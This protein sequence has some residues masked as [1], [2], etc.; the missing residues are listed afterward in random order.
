MALS[1]I[2]MRLHH[3]RVFVCWGS[4]AKAKRGSLSGKD[5]GPNASSSRPI[6]H[7]GWEERPLLEKETLSVGVRRD[8]GS[9]P[10]GNQQTQPF[11]AFKVAP[12]SLSGS[13]DFVTTDLGQ[14]FK[15]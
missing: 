11:S 15:Q 12:R 7:G 10:R 14:S 1:A 6:R 8:P 13:R 3:L 5:C 4:A 9:S 2:F